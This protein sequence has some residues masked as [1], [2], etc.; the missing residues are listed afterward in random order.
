M[1]DEHLLLLDE[2]PGW[3]EHK[4]HRRS[5]LA[6]RFRILLVIGDD[7]GDF[8][9]GVRSDVTPEQRLERMYRNADLWGSRWFILPN[10][11]YG[12]WRRA[13]GSNPVD[14]LELSP[15]E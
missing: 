9:A 12:S 5:Y 4:T 6:Q 15:V 2:R 13:L 11:V 3:D 8:V 14:H 1:R 7:L 10:P